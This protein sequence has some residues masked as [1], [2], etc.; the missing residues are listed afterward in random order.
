M[1]MEIHSVNQ[2]KIFSIIFVL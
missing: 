2:M 1:E